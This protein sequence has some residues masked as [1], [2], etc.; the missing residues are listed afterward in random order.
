MSISKE[1]MNAISRRLSRAIRRETRRVAHEAGVSPENALASVGL[2][3]MTLGSATLHAVL[4]VP[5]DDDPGFEAIG[6]Y[7]DR[8]QERGLM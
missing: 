7:V 5:L 4:D 6:R 2:V 1:Q 3:A 8:L